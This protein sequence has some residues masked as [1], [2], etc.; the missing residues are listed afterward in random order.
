MD[1]SHQQSYQDLKKQIDNARSHQSHLLIFSFVGS[2]S[3]YLFKSIVA[4]DKKLTYI[5]SINQDLGDYSLLDL[6]LSDALLF[7]DQ[8]G[9]NQKCAVLI[10]NGL[11][12]HSSILE[13]Y[14]SHFYLSTPLG[15][16]SLDDTRLLALE[17]NP[18][19]TK[20]EIGEI[21]K[22]SQGIGKIIKYLAVN[23]TSLSSQDNALSNLAN[24]VIT[25]LQGYTPEEI[26]SLGISLPL[27]GGGHSQFSIIINFDLSFVEDGHQS[28][29]ILTPSESKIL[30]KM[31]DN[32][33]QISKEQVSDIKWGE[34]KYDEFSDQAI[35]KSIRRL[36][37]KLTRHTIKTIPKIGFTLQ[38]K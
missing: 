9:V 8:A 37:S 25:S 36:N 18:K 4:A 20:K 30:K 15:C 5:N 29:E 14:K 17:I 22:L 12:F 27:I 11:D 23:P 31:T 38:T 32:H 16:R 34:N 7:V 6:S 10:N 1:V 28:P 26:N 3:S 2:G 19:L 13:K 21:Y 35:N 24:D 33:G